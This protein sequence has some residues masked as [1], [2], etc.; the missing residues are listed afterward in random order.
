MK[1]KI[2]WII[3]G[4]IAGILMILITS[5]I[6]LIENEF[7]F[8]GILRKVII[9]LIVGLGYSLLMKYFRNRKKNAT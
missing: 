7:T 6:A 5:I 9:Y 1:T 2:H 8:D 4:I 3:E